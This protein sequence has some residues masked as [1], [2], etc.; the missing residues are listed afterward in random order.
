[1]SEMRASLGPSV[2]QQDAAMARLQARDGRTIIL[3]TMP[4]EERLALAQ[5]QERFYRLSA[6]QFRREAIR[7]EKIADRCHREQLTLMRM[8]AERETQKDKT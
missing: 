4:L 8:K 3:G 6:T 7:A 1:M 5:D 2:K